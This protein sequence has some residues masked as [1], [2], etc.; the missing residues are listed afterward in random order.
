[1][2]QTVTK[3]KGLFTVRF[4]EPHLSTPFPSLLFFCLL[5][6]IIIIFYTSQLVVDQAAECLSFF[7][8]SLHSAVYH[9]ACFASFFFLLN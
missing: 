6:I 3:K 9:Y 4:D 8:N 5:I 7:F 1:M 2:K